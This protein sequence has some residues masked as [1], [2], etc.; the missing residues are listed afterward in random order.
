MVSAVSICGA[1]MMMAPV[2]EASPV[3]YTF[4]GLTDVSSSID[5]AYDGSFAYNDAT[6]SKTG[7]ES[8]NLSSL[9][10][11]FLSTAFTLANQEFASTADFLDGV[12]LGLSYTVNSTEP[13]FSFISASGNG[14]TAYFSYAPTSG[15]SGFG[16][17]T[18]VADVAVSA[19]P[20]PAAVWLFTSVLAGFG[21]ITHRKRQNTL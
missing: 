2:S 21:A 19:V 6:L 9:S 14:D 17:L 16:S 20:V 3:S 8:I 4:S 5:A 12:F 11:N 7:K 15:D 18:Y 1:L 13:K 10:F